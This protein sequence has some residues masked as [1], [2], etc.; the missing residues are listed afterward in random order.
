MR[1]LFPVFLLLLWACVPGQA[2]DTP[3]KQL[4]AADAAF[5]AVVNTAT[6]AIDTG[7][8]DPASDAGQA[9]KAAVITGKAA[10]DSA[11]L[12]LANGDMDQFQ[13]KLAVAQSTIAVIRQILAQAAP[14]PS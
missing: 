4:L 6:N 14:P 8:L 12:A 5:T 2:L 3:N 13:A 9:V 11:H 7:V 1:K 10:L